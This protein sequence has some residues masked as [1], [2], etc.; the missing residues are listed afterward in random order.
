[1]SIIYNNIST[2]IAWIYITCTKFV[3]LLILESI[4]EDYNDTMTPDMTVNCTVAFMTGCNSWVKCKRSC[5]SM[6]AA[7]YR[8]FHDGCCQCV[9]NTC[10]NYGLKQSK[11]SKCPKKKKIVEDEY[12][13]YGQDDDIFDEN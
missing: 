4:D 3:L 8:W 1:M 9:G 5:Q 11:C 7:S 2:N 13:D 12:D 10:L 6:G